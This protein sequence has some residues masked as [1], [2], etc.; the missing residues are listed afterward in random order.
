MSQIPISKNDQE[1]V[2]SPFTGVC[3]FFKTSLGKFSELNNLKPDLAIIGVPYDM[4]TTARSGARFGPRAIREASTLFCDGLDGVYDP[5]R[6]ITFMDKGQL[7]VDYGDVDIIQADRIKSFAN[8]EYAV[9]QIV[10]AGIKPVIV[11]GDH[12][13]T[14]PAAKALQLYSDICLIQLDAH[15]DWSDRPGGQ[16]YGHGSPVRR[17][18]EMSHFNQI[19]QIGLRGLGSSTP[20]DFLEARSWGSKSRAYSPG[21]SSATATGSSGKSFSSFSQTLRTVA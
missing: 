14:I 6:D 4:G 21:T 7:I 1:I 8:I 19:I 12:S 2:N 18:S 16:K 13:V 11:G 9:D 17:I 10:G 5:E 3:T 20:K 15:L